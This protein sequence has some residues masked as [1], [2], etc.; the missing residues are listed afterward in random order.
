M[1]KKILIVGCS[2]SHKVWDGN[3]IAHESWADWITKEVG[4]EIYV[5]NLSMPGASNEL[6]KRI[7]TKKI[8]NY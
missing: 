4:D 2:F 8:Y 1:R 7:V 3:D 5:M 6:I